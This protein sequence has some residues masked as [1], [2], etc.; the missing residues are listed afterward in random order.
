MWYNNDDYNDYYK[1]VSP[2]P[3]RG[4]RAEEDGDEDEILHSDG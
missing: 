4:G 2:R 1:P 3:M